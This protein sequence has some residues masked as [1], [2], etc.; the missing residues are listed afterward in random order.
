VVAVVVTIM[1]VVSVT[2]VVVVLSPVVAETPLATLT[3][4]AEFVPIVVGLPAI[5]AVAV[6][7]A[8]Q[9]LFPVLDVSVTAIPVVCEDL[10]GNAEKH[11]PTH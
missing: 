11:E 10:W 2:I 8:I 1:I 5:E 4:F 6:N 9:F 7:V 3:G